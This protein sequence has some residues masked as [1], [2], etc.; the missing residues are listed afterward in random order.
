[1]KYSISSL[2]SLILISMASRIA[3]QTS[4]D[5]DSV[6]SVFFEIVYTHNS[7]FLSY[8]DWR[9]LVSTVKPTT[10]PVVRSW[11]SRFSTYSNY[12]QAFSELYRESVFPS[13]A[14]Y[15]Y[16]TQFYP[17]S[18]VAQIA[19]TIYVVS[20]TTL[21]STSPTITTPP[22]LTSAPDLTTTTDTYMDSVRSV[23]FEIVDEHYLEFLS[24]SDWLNL[25]STVKPT[26]GTIVQSFWSR[27]S[28]YSDDQEIFD[29]AFPSSAYYEYLTQFYPSSIVAQITSTMSRR[30]STTSSSTS[31]TITTSPSRSSVPASRSTSSSA[32]ST[33][34]NSASSTSP[35]SASSTEPLNNAVATVIPYTILGLSALVA[36]IMLC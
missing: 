15:E 10:G 1:M 6:R 22:S 17:T 8:S 13:S 16:L 36:G 21:T 5:M 26:H 3:A 7:E 30:S 28:T 31:S 29:S 19:S 35:S 24:N 12:R 27:L 32:S 14:Y 25:Q 2:I 18:I 11:F 23:F 33:T 9:S 20:S 4:V 34:T